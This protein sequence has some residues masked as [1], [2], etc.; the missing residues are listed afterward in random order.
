MNNFI[1]FKTAVQ[2]TFSAITLNSN[3]LFKT[4][5]SKDD[6]WDTYLNSF[7]EGTNPIFR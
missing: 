6:L 2:Q 7:P 1:P 3:P 4:D 5:V